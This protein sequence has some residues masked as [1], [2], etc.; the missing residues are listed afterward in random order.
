MQKQLTEARKIANK[1]KF[2]TAE[3]ES[4]MQVV[5]DLCNKIDAAKPAEQHYSVD[6]GWLP[7]MLLDGRIIK[8]NAK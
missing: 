5:R 2:G 3:W 1:F 4:A 7:T 8:A 6:A